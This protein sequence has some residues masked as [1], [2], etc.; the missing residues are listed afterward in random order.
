MYRVIDTIHYRD[1]WTHRYP[2]LA[3]RGEG[4]M[5]ILEP[6]QIKEPPDIQGRTVA[7]HKPDGNIS[8]FVAADA[9]VHH[10]VVGIFFRGISAEEIPLGSQLEW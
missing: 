10:S 5:A 1:S 2:E 9:E 6:S 8:R 7:I 3:Q 4:V